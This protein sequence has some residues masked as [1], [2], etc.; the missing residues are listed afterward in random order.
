MF[1]AQHSL[2]RSIPWRLALLPPWAPCCAW[3]LCRGRGGVHS[4]RRRPAR[5]PQVPCPPTC[6][7][8][9]SLPPPHL[10]LHLRPPFVCNI[11]GRSVALVQKICRRSRAST[12]FVCCQHL[13]ATA[14]FVWLTGVLAGWLMMAASSLARSLARLPALYRGEKG[15]RASPSQRGSRGGLDPG[16]FCGFYR[17]GQQCLP[18]GA[19]A[20]SPTQPHFPCCLPLVHLPTCTP[21]CI[22]GTDVPRV[23]FVFAVEMLRAPNIYN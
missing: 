18:A 22:S 10:R 12:V 6:P 20:H 8:C 16:A 1:K 15:L 4:S 5:R 7:S 19:H 13:A 21:A 11:S 17:C 2:R 3:A 23:A 9:G 14:S